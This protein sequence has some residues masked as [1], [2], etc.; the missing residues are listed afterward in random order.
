MQRQH[1]C[2][3]EKGR[4]K[5]DTRIGMEISFRRPL[6]NTIPVVVCQQHWTQQNP[7]KEEGRG[8]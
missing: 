2:L 6:T 4:T 1:C 5:N 3:K 7:K 8:R